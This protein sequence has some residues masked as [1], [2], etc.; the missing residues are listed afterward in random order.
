ME[1]MKP[2]VTKKHDFERR[3]QSILF[4]ILLT[5]GDHIF[6]AETNIDKF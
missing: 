4:A 2:A 5:F 1:H 3:G 6:D